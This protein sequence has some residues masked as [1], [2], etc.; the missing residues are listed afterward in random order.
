MTRVAQK[1]PA[2]PKSLAWRLGWTMNLLIGQVILIVLFVTYVLRLVE[3]VQNTG[4]FASIQLETSVRTLESNIEKLEVVPKAIAARQ[5]VYG[6]SPDP[7]MPAFIRDLMRQVP[8]NDVYGSYI[9]YDAKSSKD[10]NGYYLIDRK[11]FPN[12]AY[13]SYDFHDKDQLW[14]QGAIKSKK[15]FITEPYFDEG[16]SN[17]LMVSMTRPV[18]TESGSLIGVTGVDFALE[19]IG[20]F[21]TN[22]GRQGSDGKRMFEKAK[23]ENKPIRIGSG[24]LMEVTSDFGPRAP[25]LKLPPGVKATYA[26]LVSAN[27]K[28]ISHPKQDSKTKQTKQK[29]SV[30]SEFMK[31]ISE[32]FAAGPDADPAE[33]AAKLK[34]QAKENSTKPELRIRNGMKI[35]EL[36][37]GAD[38]ASQPR[39]MTYASENGDDRILYW[40]TSPKTGWKV[41]LSFPVAQIVE[42]LKDLS[43]KTGRLALFGLILTAAIIGLVLR[44]VLR[45]LALLSR[46]TTEMEK[47][48]FN[49]DSLTKTARRKDD[50]GFLAHGFIDMAGQVKARE[51]RLEE[52]NQGLESTVADRTAALAD[53][54]QKADDARIEAEA[55]REDAEEANRTK[56][57]F[58]ANMSHE[59]RTPMNAIIGYSEMLMEEAEDVGQ[60]DFIPDLKRIHGAGKHLLMLIN[61]ILD[62]SKIEAGKMTTFCETVD[63]TAVVDE[64]RATVTPLIQ[65][66]NNK[67]VIDV[68]PEIGTIYSDLTKL[69]QTLFNLLSN[70]SKFTEGGTITLSAAPVPDSDTVVFKVTDTGIG[71][72]PEQLSKLFQAFTQADASTTR[73]Y[74]GT[75]LGLAISRKFCQL[76]G[77]DITV[78]S[79]ENVGSTFIVTLPRTAPVVTETPDKDAAQPAR[80][81]V[82]STANPDGR[83]VVVAIDDDPDMLTLLSRNLTR[84]GYAVVTASTGQ[85]GIR[86]V[87]EL[88]PVAV[89]TDILMP[90][91]DGWMVM[92]AIK[93]NPLTRQIPVILVSVSDT[94]DMGVS[95]GAFEFVSKPV[96]WSRLAII[97]RGIAATA[98]G[99]LLVVEDDA[100]MRALWL[101]NLTKDGYSVETATNGRD[102]LAKV[103]AKRPAAILLDL[104][105]P[106]MDGFEFLARLRSTPDGA[107]IPVIVVTAKQLSAADT[108]F[109]QDRVQAVMQKAGNDIDSVLEAVRRQV[110]FEKPA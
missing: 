70:A 36:P 15:Q 52:L 41:V 85:E 76:L 56:S 97:L 88:R 3:L 95:L 78:E 35:T 11:S 12:L 33:F 13:I 73:K 8:K 49:P 106:E 40:D 53:A 71:M 108:A 92:D 94:R 23:R 66:N 110:A 90:G 102:A 51:K 9:Y 18:Y 87:N 72:T 24:G 22:V 30:G 99:H 80:V 64:V 65:K 60:E 104:M 74:G 2:K 109:L 19:S 4:E 38:I 28:L 100:D 83:P 7:G 14:Y 61:D 45:P 37:G 98:S 101:R 63:I 1:R 29:E 89:T 17:I 81:I 69:R 21:V 32:G 43:I 107:G 26:F 82:E 67:L 10:A 75:G 93:S 105:M 96:D 59:L 84:E 42:P 79:T 47:G 16:G 25:A 58:L 86:L 39:G 54:L 62:L 77:G 91:M 46:S 44:A 27:G 103:T 34:R 5:R 68:A 50:L 55:A 57:S 31:G 6:T 48:T 20:S